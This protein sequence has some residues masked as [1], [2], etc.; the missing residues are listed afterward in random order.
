M[1]CFVLSG[2]ALTRMT[3]ALTQPFG[4][5]TWWNNSTLR[6]QWKSSPPALLNDSSNFLST[7]QWTKKSSALS[8]LVLSDTVRPPPWEQLAARQCTS[9]QW[10]RLRNKRNVTRAHKTLQLVRKT[11]IRGPV[12]REFP[13]KDLFR[14]AVSHNGSAARSQYRLLG[15]HRQCL[16][17]DREPGKRIGGRASSK[18]HHVLHNKRYDWKRCVACTGLPWQLA[19]LAF[20]S[21]VYSLFIPYLFN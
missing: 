13:L 9:P 1:R 10:G 6:A 17:F 8:Y 3:P 4:S 11:R 18:Q 21:G 16:S 7:E 20:Q 14:A 2:D 19:F 15:D 5:M 12:P